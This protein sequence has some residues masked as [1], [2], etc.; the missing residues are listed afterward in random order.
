MY[1]CRSDFVYDLFE[2]MSTTEPGA[3]GGGRPSRPTM[4]RKAGKPSRK[5][6]TVSS[7]FKVSRTYYS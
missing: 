6:A 3:G 2:H 4:I 5:K 1:F 7:Q